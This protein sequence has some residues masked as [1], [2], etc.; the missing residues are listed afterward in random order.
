MLFLRFGVVFRE[1]GFEILEVLFEE[2]LLNILDVLGVF[3]FYFLGLF[4]GCRE[5]LIK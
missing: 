1:K 2:G 4:F 5:Y 3:E